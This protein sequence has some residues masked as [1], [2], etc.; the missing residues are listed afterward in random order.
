MSSAGNETAVFKGNQKKTPQPEMSDL[1][2]YLISKG[3]EQVRL[4][5]DP[6]QGMILAQGNWMINLIAFGI[7]VYLS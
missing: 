3:L 6:S 4:P 7:T 1:R 2:Q 5:L